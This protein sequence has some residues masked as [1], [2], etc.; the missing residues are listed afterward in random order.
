[1]KHLSLLIVS[2]LVGLHQKRLKEKSAWQSSRIS[3][4]QW[5][6]VAVPAPVP[7]Q[8]KNWKSE[9]LNTDTQN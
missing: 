6:R 8:L 1:M 9:K 4:F 7:K 2:L 3:V 5:P